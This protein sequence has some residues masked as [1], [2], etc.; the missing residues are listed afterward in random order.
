MMF[1]FVGVIVLVVAYAA[2]ATAAETTG[3][4]G[5]SDDCTWT[6]DSDTGKLVVEGTGEI[7]KDP[8]WRQNNAVMEGLQSVEI[9]SGIL[10]IGA[11]AFK[12]CKALTSVSI[13]DSV[14]TL[15]TSIFY[16]CKALTSVKLPKG[17]IEMGTSTFRDCTA[18]TTVDIP[19]GITSIASYTFS[20]SGLTSIKIPDSVLGVNNSVF[21]GCRSL[22][23]AEIPDSVTYL[24]SF[25]FSVCPNLTS[26]KLPKNLVRIGDQ[27]FSASGLTSVKI[28]KSVTTIGDLVFSG[29]SSMT[30]IEVESGNSV[31]KSEDGMLLNK[32]G[33]LLQ[34]PCG[35]DTVKIPK[36]VTSINKNAFHHSQLIETV[37]IPDSV[38]SLSYKAFGDCGKLKSVTIEKSVTSI[39]SYAFQDCKALTT[40]CY[41]GEKDPGVA[42][43]VFN[44]CDSL[45][46]VSV[47]DKYKDSKFCG[48]EVEKSDSCTSPKSSG[49]ELNAIPSKWIVKALVLM[50][51]AVVLSVMA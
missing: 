19:E 36:S 12:D 46:K 17:L 5:S 6:F 35:K 9:K 49:A 4:C 29:C 33:S 30:S 40:V 8:L 13:A 27:A 41:L 18:L 11:N 32:T 1:K 43:N 44:G 21:S 24:S 16:G 26:V 2:A 10:S 39:D 34:F 31:Y 25:A 23:S 20:S 38:V 7:P 51:P 47:T 48:S 22:K 45:G 42:T 14:T 37:V 28:P 15:Q 50:I 3:Y